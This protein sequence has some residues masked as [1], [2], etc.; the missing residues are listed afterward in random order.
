MCIFQ[1]VGQFAG[2]ARNAE[3]L[4][5]AYAGR[6]EVNTL[7]QLYTGHPCDPFDR[8]S[9]SN[10]HAR[11]ATWTKQT[12]DCK[13]TQYHLSVSQP[14]SS[15]PWNV[16]T[17]AAS[18]RP[19]GREC[20]L[21]PALSAGDSRG[22]YPVAGAH[23]ADG[24]GKIIPYSAFG[25]SQ[26]GGY[27]STLHAF[28]GQAQDL[29]FAIGERIHLGPG[30][31]GEIG[32]NDAQALLHTAHGVGKFLGTHVFQQVSQGSRFHGAT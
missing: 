15:G 30:F 20:P 5:Y 16:T 22:F 31:R 26:L 3:C 7:H 9:V 21:E 12:E 4:D 10:C 6:N 23:L 1:V 13:L 8:Y 28:A 18:K 25:E 32:M 2:R 24:F 14:I 29:A 19:S 27:I 11:S 17:G